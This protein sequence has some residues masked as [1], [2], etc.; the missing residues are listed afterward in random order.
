M[1]VASA[2][3][4]NEATTAPVKKSTSL[5]NGSKSSDITTTSL[6]DNQ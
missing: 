6:N 2:K 4:S 5:I 1:F 3:I